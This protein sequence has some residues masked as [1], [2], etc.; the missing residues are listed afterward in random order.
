MSSREGGCLGILVADTKD[1]LTWGIV[2]CGSYG[3]KPFMGIV[4]GT[5]WAYLSE[6][7]E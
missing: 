1:D 7:S 3:K 6:P 4:L 2:E 5:K